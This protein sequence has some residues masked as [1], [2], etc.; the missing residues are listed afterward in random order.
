MPAHSYMTGCKGSEFA[1]S[2]QPRNRVTSHQLFD[3]DI[4][5]TEPQFRGPHPAERCFKLKRSAYMYA[6]SYHHMRLYIHN[7]PFRKPSRA[8]LVMSFGGQCRKKTAIFY[9]CKGFNKD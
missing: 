7:D 4:G 1:V 8:M 9:E 2:A 3:K 6:R 5:H